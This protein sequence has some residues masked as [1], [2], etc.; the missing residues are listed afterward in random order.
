MVDGFDNSDDFATFEDLQDLLVVDGFVMGYKYTGLVTG[1]VAVGFVTGGGEV[2]DG[3]D[4]T[5]TTTYFALSVLSLFFLLIWAHVRGF[6]ALSVLSP[7]F[8]LNWARVRGFSSSTH[9]MCCVYECAGVR[10]NAALS[11][12]TL[13]EPAA[14][15]RANL[16][17]GKRKYFLMMLSL[18][19]C[20]VGAM[21]GS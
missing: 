10:F 15:K 4:A 18:S 20:Q 6:S 5:Y 16:D 9:S 2:A 3:G 1:G 8:L 7:F 11:D 21:T 19:P 17:D 14:W 13:L 12:S